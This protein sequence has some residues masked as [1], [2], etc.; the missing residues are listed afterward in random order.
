MYDL[1]RFKAAL[2]PYAKRLPSGTFWRY[3]NGQ[4]PPP[5]GTLLLESPELA[6]ALAED[7]AEL[8]RQR[9]ALQTS[10]QAVKG[11]EAA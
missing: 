2:K 10:D 8:A 9:Q 1:P 7:V 4:L 11:G 3:S 5:L 6:A